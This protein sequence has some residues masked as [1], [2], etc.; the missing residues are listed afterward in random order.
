[1]LVQPALALAAPPPGPMP[2]AN[3]RAPVPVYRATPSP[4]RSRSAADGRDDFKLPF[5][6][7]VRPKGLP[8]E[9]NLS[10]L[11]AGAKLLPYRYFWQQPWA[12]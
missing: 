9:P 4:G 2:F 7:D 6:L 11:E 12:W 3:Y 10:A 5:D 1:M 8:G